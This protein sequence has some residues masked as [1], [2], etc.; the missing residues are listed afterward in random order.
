MSQ[1]LARNLVHLVFSTKSRQPVLSQSVRAPQCVY[2][3]GIFRKRRI[4]FEEELRLLLQPH[5]VEFDERYVLDWACIAA[6]LQ[7]AER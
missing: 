5:Q 7:G 3:A 1:S 4:G 6:P 2:A